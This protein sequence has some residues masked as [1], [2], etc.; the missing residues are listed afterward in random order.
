MYIKMSEHFP[1]IQPNK[2]ISKDVSFQS[3]LPSFPKLPNSKPKVHNLFKKYSC[4]RSSVQKGNISWEA[5][6][7]FPTF[8]LKDEQKLR[9]ASRQTDSKLSVRRDS[10]T[11][12]ERN[13]LTEESERINRKYNRRS[14]NLCNQATKI[15]FITKQPAIIENIMRKHRKLFQANDE[16]IKSVIGP[17][18]HSSQ[19]V[20]NFRL[21]KSRRNFSSKCIYRISSRKDI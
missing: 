7:N 10:S 3:F 16:G 8:G 1:K 17:S 14:P 4:R 21:F 9:S 13:V 6:S 20:N 18:I 19:S 12:A 11:S 15:P 5:D 2:N